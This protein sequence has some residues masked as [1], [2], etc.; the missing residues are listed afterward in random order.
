MCT[1]FSFYPGAYVN[2]STFELKF[3]E[4][5]TINPKDL[6]VRFKEKNPQIKMMLFLNYLDAFIY[7]EM[8]S[9]TAFIKSA[10]QVLKS[11]DL[12][13][14]NLN[15]DNLYTSDNDDNFKFL[16]QQ[17]RA[18]FTFNGLHLSAVVLS[19]KKAVEARSEISGRYLS[20]SYLQ[21]IYFTYCISIVFPLN[22][23]TKNEP[24]KM[25][26]SRC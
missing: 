24:K 15:L 26:T 17:L 7:R 16:M 10:V 1:H 6:V 3:D 4:T 18:A 23:I 9:I 8:N 21:Y 25:T 19:N 5:L 11:N 22:Q 13:G 20:L 2:S 14:L 12:D